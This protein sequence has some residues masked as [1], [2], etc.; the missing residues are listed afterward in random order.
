MSYDIDDFQ[1][2]VNV[3]LNDIANIPVNN[4]EGFVKLVVHILSI[5]DGN[6]PDDLKTSIKSYFIFDLM[7]NHTIRERTY[8][9]GPK[10]IYA[11]LKTHGVFP[12]NS[13]YDDNDNG[14]TQHFDDYDYFENLEKG[15]ERVYKKR[16]NACTTIEEA[17][18]VRDTERAKL[19]V[20]GIPR[21]TNFGEFM[22]VCWD[23][24]DYNDNGEWEH[25]ETTDIYVD[26]YSLMYD[27]RESSIKMC[28][29][30]HVNVI[31]QC[32]R[33]ECY[34]FHMYYET[35]NEKAKKSLFICECGKQLL[36][37]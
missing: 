32:N 21:Y 34:S 18:T 22:S 29:F 19:N 8:D 3:Y 24:H 33:P 6:I 27:N 35:D 15:M 12:K 30:G 11:M 23:I 10:K 20:L 16:L 14:F 5:T 37:V 26:H 28:E 25:D 7:Y 36:D 2:R 17:N 1:K 31:C 4:L 9:Y 13:E